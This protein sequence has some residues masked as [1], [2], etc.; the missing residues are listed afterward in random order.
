[1][2]KRVGWKVE[3]ELKTIDIKRTDWNSAWSSEN[4]SKVPKGDCWYDKS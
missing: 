3:E 2:I 1:M 4:E